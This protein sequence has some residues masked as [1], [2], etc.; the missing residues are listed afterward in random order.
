M[1]D[2][3]KRTA[4]KNADFRQQKAKEA[5]KAQEDLIKQQKEEEAKKT[6]E[7][8][9]IEN[10]VKIYNM[11]VEKTNTYE[12]AENKFFR[13]L[14]PHMCNSLLPNTTNKE[15]K[16]ILDT[17]TSISGSKATKQLSKAFYGMYSFYNGK[18]IKD[19][20]IQKINSP[21]TL[22]ET[23]KAFVREIIRFC[24][25]VPAA[26]KYVFGDDSDSLIRGYR[27]NRENK[28]DFTAA[29]NSTDVGSFVQ[30]FCNEH[31]LSLQSHIS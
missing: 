1:G 11:C 20:D 16:E 21:V 19:Q 6:P 27:S 25:I 5:K 17:K 30:K 8:K 28:N 4:E 2:I 18:E 29:K 7:Q 22:P 14:I 3:I 9:A 31:H 15:L 12:D 13:A 26:A 10:I 24:L 23:L